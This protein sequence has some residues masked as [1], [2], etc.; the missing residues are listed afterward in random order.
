MTGELHQRFNSAETLTALEIATE[1]RELAL[2]RHALESMSENTIVGKLT[3]DSIT[4]RE[5]TLNSTAR[6]RGLSAEV[7]IASIQLTI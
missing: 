1:L 6:D 7:K 4:S 3:I 2:V 5:N